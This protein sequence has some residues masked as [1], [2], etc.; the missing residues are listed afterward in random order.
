MAAV[1]NA[2]SESVIASLL[3]AGAAPQARNADGATFP[4][5]LESL[6]AEYPSGDFSDGIRRCQ[7]VLYRHLTPG[8]T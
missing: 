7:Q 3:R 6:L 2:D 8:E 5:Y 1:T 4:E